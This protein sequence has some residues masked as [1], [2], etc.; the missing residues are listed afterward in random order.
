MAVIVALYF[1]TDVVLTA[2]YYTANFLA[3]TYGLP[4][5]TILLLIAAI[6]AIGFPATWVAGHLA[7][8]YGAKHVLLWCVLAW[9]VTLVMLSRAA[10]LSVVCVLLGLTV[11]STQAVGRTLLAKVVPAPRAAEFFG[12][13]GLSSKIAASVGPLIFGTVSSLAG[14]QRVAWLSLVP[15]LAIGAILLAPIHEPVPRHWDTARQEE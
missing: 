10:T 12:Y 14:D 15:L 7:D 11:G 3:T 8:R 2:I 13:N 1:I 9:F 4:G 6:Q 5:R